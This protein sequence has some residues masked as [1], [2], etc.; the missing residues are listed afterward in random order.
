MPRHANLCNHWK[1]FGFIR[2]EV[3]YLTAEEVELFVSIIKI[4]NHRGYSYVLAFAF[5]RALRQ[6]WAARSERCCRST[7]IK[8]ISNERRRLS[9]AKAEKKE[10]SAIQQFVL[11][12]WRR[13][14]CRWVLPLNISSNSTF[15]LSWLSSQNIT[16]PR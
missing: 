12:R 6:S 3:A 13:Y 14:G 16:P 2:K 7:A 9:S 10:P 1:T 11:E 5:E 4:E 8:S 15:G